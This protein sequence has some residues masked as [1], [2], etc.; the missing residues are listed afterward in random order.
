MPRTS[1][2]PGHAPLV[3]L[4]KIEAHIPVRVRGR[5]TT[6]KAVNGVSLSI[7]RGETLGLVGESGGGKST[8]G[9]IIA[10]LRKPTAGRVQ[11]D[12]VDL[13][14]LSHRQLR[15]MRRRIQVVFQDPYSS[16]DPRMRA[17]ELIAEPLVIH[18]LGNA[19][20]RQKRVAELLRLVDLPPDAAGRYPSEFSGGQRQRI[21][22]ARA[23]AVEPDFLILDEPI[24]ALDISIQAQILNLL[25]NLRDEMGLTFLFIGH[26]LDVV[27]HISTRVAVLYL[28]TIAEIGDTK[29]IMESPTHPYTEALLEARPDITDRRVRKTRGQAAR[30]ELPSPIT[31]PSGCTFH[32]RCPLY[33]QLGRPSKC[34]SDV[35]ILHL[36]STSNEAACHFAGE[37][38]VDQKGLPTSTKRSYT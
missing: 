24:S 12:G 5:A 2:P 28:G 38:S 20:E 6:V 31:P 17:G 32:P 29:T 3:H 36:T 8:L 4:E 16:L 25:M 30:G 19:D 27:R 35:P 7:H 26:D 11:F 10:G 18:R 34:Q 13:A 37:S 33:E 14:T 15:R 9:R 22:I 23:L 1:G 21:G